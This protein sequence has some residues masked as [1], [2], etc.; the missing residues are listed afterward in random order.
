MPLLPARLELNAEGVPWSAA[1][2]DVYHSASGA[3]EQTEHVFLAGNGLPA[4]WQAARDF[5]IV[6]TGFGL[7]LNFLHTW[8][9]WREMRLPGGH[10]HFLSVEKH[11]FS[12][13]DLVLAHDHA[14]VPAELACLLQARWPDLSPGLHHL[15][16]EAEALTLSLGF[17]EA[18]ELLPC[19]K[20]RADAVFLDGFSPAQNPDMW[21]AGIFEALAALSHAGTTLATWSVA[22]RVRAGLREA[23]FAVDKVPGFGSKRQMLTGKRQSVLAADR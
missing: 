18:I 22:G 3:A 15:E 9:R 6:E 10:L 2:G 19:L 11:P 5:V 16:F 14:G 4:R 17:G 23:G 13:E 12:R 20:T 1:Y 8:Q 21:S 7:G